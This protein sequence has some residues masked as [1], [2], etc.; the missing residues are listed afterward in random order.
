MILWKSK[1]NLIN[2]LSDMKKFFVLAS[3]ITVSSLFFAC[4]GAQNDNGM[5]SG[6]NGVTN[7][8][9]QDTIRQGMPADTTNGNGEGTMNG[10]EGMAPVY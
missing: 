6:R 2:N 3:A 4:N 8:Q 7:G 1:F 10:D 9:Q 5:D